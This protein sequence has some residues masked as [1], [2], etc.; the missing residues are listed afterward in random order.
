M[1]KS[2][3]APTKKRIQTKADKDFFK[4]TDIVIV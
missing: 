3:E 4:D 2:R 1:K